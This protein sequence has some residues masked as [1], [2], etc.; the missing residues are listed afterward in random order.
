MSHRPYVF[1]RSFLNRM[2]RGKKR[3][4]P[5]LYEPPDR[6]QYSPERPGAKRVDT[7]APGSCFIACGNPEIA[8]CPIGKSG[9]PGCLKSCLPTQYFYCPANQDGLPYGSG[10]ARR[11]AGRSFPASS[12]SHSVS[13]FSGSACVDFS[14]FKC[15]MGGPFRYPRRRFERSFFFRVIGKVAPDG[16]VLSV[17]LSGNTFSFL[18]KAGNGSSETERV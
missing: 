4:I 1:N 8:V 17:V 9:F 16:C 2:G 11:N 7:L 14:M 15:S 12:G 18:Q 6:S 5:K 13:W 10:T 3:G